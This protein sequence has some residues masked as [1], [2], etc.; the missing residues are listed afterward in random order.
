VTSWPSRF[1]FRASNFIR[2]L[3]L[4]PKFGTEQCHCGVSVLVHVIL[5]AYWEPRDFELPILRSG[6]ENWRRW[7]D[8]ALDPPN[9]ICE[10]N[11]EQPVLGQ[12]IVLPHG[13][14]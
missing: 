6:R 3:R 1:Q 5:N 11:S 12:R 14:W 13:R 7:I 10:W 4:M 2:C 9:E 8:T